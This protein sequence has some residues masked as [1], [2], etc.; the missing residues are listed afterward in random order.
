MPVSVAGGSS[1]MFHGP[2]PGL[3][4]SQS[5]MLLGFVC[6]QSIETVILQ[7]KLYSHMI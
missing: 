6:E 7:L 3:H 1:S 5:V 2:R 4:V